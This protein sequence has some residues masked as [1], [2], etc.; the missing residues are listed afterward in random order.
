MQQGKTARIELIAED[1]PSIHEEIGSEFEMGEIIAAHVNDANGAFAVCPGGGGRSEG[2]ATRSEPRHDWH[3][4]EE[5][6]QSDDHQ[7]IGEGRIG[8][9]LDPRIREENR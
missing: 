3:F 6:Y 2:A 1:R 5:T 9:D 8:G 7:A 4:K